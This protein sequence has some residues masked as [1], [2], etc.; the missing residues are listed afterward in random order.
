MRPGPSLF[1]LAER[2]LLLGLLILRGAALYL[3]AALQSRGLLRGEADLSRARYTAFAR[4]FVD[5]ATRFRGALIKLGQVASLRIDVLPEAISDELAR[6]QD[7]VPPHPFKEIEARIESELGG[8]L[9]DRFS[10]FTREP[11]AA[12]SLGQV[13][14][15]CSRGGERLAVKVLYPGIGRSV[16]VDLAMARLALWLFDFL[17]VAD[18]K[19]VY[20]QLRDSL[21]RELDYLREGRA[22]EE[23]ARNLRRDPALFAH[24]RVPVIHW[25]TTTRRVLSME[26]LE[27]VKINDRAAVEALGVDM[28]EVV[29]WTSRAFLHMM[30]RDGFFHCD[31]H[32]GNLLVDREGRV[33]IID[34]GMHER[35]QPALLSAIR[36]NVMASLR[37]DAA[38]YAES[39]LEM[40]MIRTEDIPHVEALAELSFDPRYYNLTPAELVELDFGE[41]FARMRKSMK[42]IKSFALPDGIVMWSR[43]IS[44]LIGLVSE[45]APG[46]RPLEVVAPYVL[47]FMQAGSPTHEFRA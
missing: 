15:A 1:S 23:C 17:V 47:E 18:L 45:L 13:H 38:L 16:A 5:L 39:L 2:A 44:L 21:L 22:A 11:L 37:R 35:I 6:L 8:R 10:D 3:R 25:E 4:R 9:S 42:Q 19:Q 31:P 14:A 20:R 41:Y 32:P 26:F 27:G 40:E 29:R 36:K 43:A 24:L 30:F 28:T 7:R 34:F 12:A 33:G 46:L